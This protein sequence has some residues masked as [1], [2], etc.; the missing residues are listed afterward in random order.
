MENREHPVIL[1]AE[2]DE[3]LIHFLRKSMENEGMQATI[4]ESGMEALK[5][6]NAIDPDLIVLD[7][8]LPDTDGYTVCKHLKGDRKTADIPVIFLTGRNDINDRLN[9]FEVGAQDYL[10]KPFE[11]PEFIARVK[12]VMRIHEEAV[13][14]KN[15][16]NKRQEDFLSILND[17]LRIPLTV[18]NMGSEIL[19][20]NRQLS[21]QRRDYL[22]HS[23]RSS[24]LTLTAIVD[25]LLYLAHPARHLKTSN[26]R[27]TVVQVAEENRQ[28]V[29]DHDLHL[30]VRLP[31]VFP[32]VVVDELRLRR[33]V[34]HLLDN[35]IKFT[36]RNGVITLTLS[37]SE[38]GTLTA[39]NHLSDNDALSA[40]PPGLVPSNAADPWLILSVRDTGIGIA[41]ENH[42]KVFEPFFQVDPSTTRQVRGLGLGL[43]VVAA[44]VRS[45]QGQI[46]VRSGDGIGTAVH[47]ALPMKQY[48][49]S[50]SLS[51]YVP[52]PEGA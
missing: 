12:A 41:S 24:S 46:A 39:A 38:N 23:I 40:F 49:D 35:A 29:K 28:K 20:N 13:E 4:V 10:V 7:V 22:I 16:M 8:G 32:L 11:M 50:R 43:A 21:A 48:S 34:Y 27:S 1:I 36:P 44:F 5:L 42:Y 19:A 6:A 30:V 31:D 52:E 9:G 45:H 33:A 25:D 2:D 3:T 18:I 17:E 26:I 14:A 51:G 47:I 37:M 15:Q